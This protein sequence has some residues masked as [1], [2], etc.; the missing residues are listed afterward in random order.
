MGNEIRFDGHEEG[1]LL[2]LD[3]V[4]SASLQC[5]DD[6]L[7]A[8]LRAFENGIAAASSW[9]QRVSEPN[10]HLDCDL[11]ERVLLLLSLSSSV[12]GSCSF[13]L[14]FYGSERL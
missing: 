5:F 9:Q 13:E 2:S 6:A 7:R 8:E 12:K 4:P 11:R 10:A 1:A 14:K 3:S